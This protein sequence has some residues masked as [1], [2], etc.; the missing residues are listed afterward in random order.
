MSAFFVL[1]RHLF[2]ATNKN[3]TLQDD[4]LRSVL[5]HHGHLAHDEN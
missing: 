4:L 3:H 5:A 1:V 2:D